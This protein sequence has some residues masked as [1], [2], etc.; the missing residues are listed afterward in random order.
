M[1]QWS[2]TFIYECIIKNIAFRNIIQSDVPMRIAGQF[3]DV[4]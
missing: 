1:F 4:A 2:S 3:S